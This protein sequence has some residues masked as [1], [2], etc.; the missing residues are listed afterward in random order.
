MKNNST[1]DPPLGSTNSAAK[2]FHA[3]VKNRENVKVTSNV[4]EI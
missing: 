1:M 3:L 2:P 4:M